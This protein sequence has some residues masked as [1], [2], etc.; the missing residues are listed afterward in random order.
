MAS[1]SAGRRRRAT[2]SPRRS[3]K[4]WPARRSSVA[5]TEADGC[6]L[7]RG[8][9]KKS[10]QTE[11][12]Y[13]K[14]VA[15]ILQKRCQACHRPDQAAPFSLLTY[16]DAVK[17]AADD[18]GSDDAAAHAALARRPA[19]RPF[20]QRPPADRA[21]RSTRWPPGSMAAC[22]AATTRTCPSR[23][24]GRRA[25]RTASRT[26]SSTMPEEFEV[27]AD[28]VRALQELDHRHEVHRGQ[29]GADRRG[30]GPAAPASCIT[31]SST[32]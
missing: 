30:A 6:L 27:P 26:W 11:V 23:S 15:P 9:A 1:A 12:T 3:T 5:E 2:T 10:T 7:D 21:R 19:L 25:G 8:G 18:Q 29:V 17:H 28:G 13:A 24:T 31:S 22:R 14:D 20:R 16:D 4:C 32:S